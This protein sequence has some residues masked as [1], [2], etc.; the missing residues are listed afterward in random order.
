MSAPH[1]EFRNLVGFITATDTKTSV[2]SWFNKRNIVFQAV[3]GVTDSFLV[4][5]EAYVKYYRWADVA[6]P[7]RTDIAMLLNQLRIWAE[8]GTANTYND[9]PNTVVQVKPMY[10]AI[11]MHVDEVR[12]DTVAYPIDSGIIANPANFGAPLDSVLDANTKCVVMTA[13]SDISGSNLGGRI[14]RATK[15]YAPSPA[16]K[17]MI[18][19]V[20]SKLVEHAGLSN[21]SYVDSSPSDLAPLEHSVFRVGVFDDFHD[22]LNGIAG[23][24]LFVEF[25]LDTDRTDWSTDLFA[26]E[27]LSEF[28]AKNDSVGRA[29]FIQDWQQNALWAV[30][31]SSASGVQR[32]I[33]VPRFRWNIDRLGKADGSIFNIDPFVS[34]TFVFQYTAA[35]GMDYRF[36]VMHRSIIHWV[37]SWDTTDVRYQMPVSTLPLRWELDNRTGSSIVKMHVGAG[38]ISCDGEHDVPG[39]L[40]SFDTH[41]DTKELFTLDQTPIISFR[42]T[43]ERNR[44]S[45]RPMRMSLLNIG[46][47]GTCKYELRLNASLT[48]ATFAAGNSYTFDVSAPTTQALPDI[49]TNLQV[50]RDATAVTGG[51][52][53]V[54]GYLFDSVVRDLS[55]E[56]SLMQ[57]HAAINGTPDVLTLVV[58]V[59]AGTVDVAASL[60]FLEHD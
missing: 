55:V 5:S 35:P 56:F 27:I 13:P 6:I 12:N 21:V 32:D 2:T 7:S 24:G 47:S 44:G 23:N 4:K 28:D 39:R 51:I 50:D 46:A 19:L 38:I 41:V 10:D 26:Q 31:R 30:L 37:H 18:A 16:D 17:R 36:G 9:K 43:P 54:S 25:S 34:N 33:R 11:S 20:S 53:L 45:L 3:D 40:V 60:Q 22:T 14:V 57:L 48:G 52:T 59:I 15:E 42:L 29:E 49:G 1:I 8:E 58:T